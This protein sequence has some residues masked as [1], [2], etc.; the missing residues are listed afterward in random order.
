[1]AASL[2]AAPARTA[3]PR[4]G[5]LRRNLWLTGAAIAALVVL[6]ALSLTLGAITLSPGQAFEGLTS[7]SDAF[8]RAVVWDIRFPRLL[9]AMLV[10]AALSVA[11]LLLQVVT[12]N[13]LAD[14]TILGVTAAAGLA[15]ATLMVMAPQI[16]QWGL[17]AVAI[18][19]G[20][21]GAGVIFAIAWQGAVSPIRLT[22]AGVALAAF[23]GAAIVALLS[24][25]RTFLQLSLGFLAG[26]LYASEWADLRA[27]LPFVL[28]ALAATYLMAS[29]L[30]VLALGDDVAA[31]LGVLTDRT[32]LLALAL[33]GVLTGAA[34]SV[35]GLVSFV[36]LVCPHLARFL[37]GTDN[38]YLVPASAVTGALLVGVADLLARLVIRPAEIPMGI[39]TAAVGAPFLLYLL[40]FQR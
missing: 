3:R 15:T 19:G 34:V 33:V 29:Q 25:S 7:E 6:T 8:A 21:V 37:V 38:R 22:L 28:P 14:P 4:H 23:F 36:G 16:S 27:M 35:A 32:R 40:R 9:D 20:L 10:G 1:M 17:A 5:S 24:S 18:G 13:P 26:G 31:G 2:S 39:I 30:N 12:R 11:G